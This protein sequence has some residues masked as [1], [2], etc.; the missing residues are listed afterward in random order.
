MYSRHLSPIVF[1][2]SNSECRLPEPFLRRCVYPHIKFDD[3]IVRRA[4]EARQDEFDTL[5][6]SF[7]DMAML[8]FL[9][10]RERSLRKQPATGELL[11]WLRFLALT[12]GTY[13]ARLDDDLSQL[14]YLGVLLKDRQDIDEVRGGRI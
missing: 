1:I 5:S 2:T 7:I 8:R 9:A 12:L 4:L 13:P 6:D 10:L 3:T 14:P 11:V